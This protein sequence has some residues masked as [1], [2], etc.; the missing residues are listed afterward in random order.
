[1]LIVWENLLCWLHIDIRQFPVIVRLISFVICYCHHGWVVNWKKTYYKIWYASLPQ[2]FEYTITWCVC[3]L[4]C[5]FNLVK[6]YS[7]LCAQANYFIS[8]EKN[9]TTTSKLKSFVFFFLFFF[10]LFKGYSTRFLEFNSILMLKDPFGYKVFVLDLD[11]Q[12]LK[13]INCLNWKKVLSKRQFKHFWVRKKDC[14]LS[15]KMISWVA[16]LQI[17]N[18][19]IFVKCWKS[20]SL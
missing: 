2:E 1:M 8:V 10:M 6:L 19:Q 4:L 13:E 7:I 9:T 17:F 3:E 5:N 15:G 12:T 18:N 11:W 16:L 14:F 20:I